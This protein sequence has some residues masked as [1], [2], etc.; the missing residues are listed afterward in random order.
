M[1]KIM[2]DSASDCRVNDS[3]CDFFAPLTVSINGNDYLDGETLDNDTFYTLLTTSEEFPKTSQPAPQRYVEDFEK[4]KEAGDELICI[5]LS[6]GLSGTYQSAMLAKD[7]VDY[8]GI[9]VVNSNTATHGIRFLLEYA[10]K[11][12][13]EGFDAKTIVEK[14]EDLKGRIRILAGLETLEYLYKGGRLSKTA[15]TVGEMANLKPL[16]TLNEEGKIDA[17]RKCIGVNRALI[18]IVK[19]FCS[20]EIDEDFPIYTVY[21]LGSEN[22]ERLEEKL[23]SKGYVTNGRFQVG[24]TIGAHIGPGAYGV[25]FVSK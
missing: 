15:A 2:V 11:L 14:L 12:V 21:T 3:K 19:D 4:V 5:T 8:D 1:I 7:I 20:T 6:A 13:E 18:A 25:I 16:V 24:S 17:Y 9:Y 10:N 22:T 23:A